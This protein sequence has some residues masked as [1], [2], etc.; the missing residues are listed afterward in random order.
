VLVRDETN[1]I[2]GIVTSADVVAAYQNLATPFMLI[3]TLDQKL[4]QLLVDN[5][6]MPDIAKL[7]DPGG[8]RVPLAF[9]DLTLGDYERVLE[10]PAMWEQLNWSLDRVAFLARLKLLRSI[11]NDVMHF[12][13]D[14]LPSDA[15]P[16]IRNILNMLDSYGAR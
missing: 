7:C 11:R 16:S 10:S 5:F 6:S 13:P 3:G 15:V 8:R 9:D 14:P 4:R 1:A 12:N 2:R